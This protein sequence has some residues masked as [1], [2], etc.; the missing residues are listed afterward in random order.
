MD[1]VLATL[2][3]SAPEDERKGAGSN[4]EK[5]FDRIVT[6]ARGEFYEPRIWNF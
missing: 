6:S 3:L 4:A 5:F 2:G 1:V